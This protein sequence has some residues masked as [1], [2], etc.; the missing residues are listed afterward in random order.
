MASPLLA[1]HAEK[2]LGPQQH[3][4]GSEYTYSTLCHNHIGSDK[5]T[6]HHILRDLQPYVCFLPACDYSA[7][8]FATKKDW[9]RHLELGHNFDIWEDMTCPLC[10]KATG[11]GKQAVVSHMSRHFEESSLTI[12]PTNADLDDDDKSEAETREQTE[13]S[14]EKAGANDSTVQEGEGRVPPL[15]FLSP[16]WKPSDTTSQTQ[17]Y[18]CRAETC[19][20]SFGRPEELEKHELSHEWPFKCP[21]PDCYH[22]HAGLLA[23]EQLDNHAY[24][25][26][27]SLPLDKLR[28]KTKEAIDR[29]AVK[30][31]LTTE[32]L[33]QPR[34][35]FREPEFDVKVVG[36]Q[37][38]VC[39]TQPCPFRSVNLVDYVRHLGVA[40]K[41]C[42]TVTTSHITG[43]V[44]RMVYDPD[45]DEVMIDHPPQESNRL[46]E[47]RKEREDRLH[48]NWREGDG[49][50]HTIRLEYNSKQTEVPPPLPL[51]KFSIPTLKASKFES[52][53]ERYAGWSEAAAG[54]A[55]I[56]GEPHIGPGDHNGNGHESAGAE[57]DG[58]LP[59][60]HGIGALPTLHPPLGPQ[61][62]LP[63]Y[64]A[65]YAGGIDPGATTIRSERPFKCDMCPQSFNRNHDLRRHKKVHLAVKPFPCSSCEK[66]FS[67][68][69]AL[70]VGAR[71]L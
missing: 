10:R 56:K 43:L 40:H 29:V 22:H 65:H 17:R 62:P 30:R 47:E 61:R 5:N 21:Q 66:S 6:R 28:F 41:F 63:P 16:Q 51:P 8:P 4:P 64:L 11:S 68:K 46:K 54:S 69:D 48:P 53:H 35:G 70:K 33:L 37:Q 14:Q 19:L 24:E 39:P 2:R 49:R 25:A 36:S 55:P 23:Q 57:P 38:I 50:I 3:Q 1:T 18:K 12:L 27:R 71:I 59:P 45:T 9:I 52:R 60:W 13:P 42:P 44:T 20:Q 67:R 34:L 26:H 7:A 15:Y 58:T 31:K 32:E